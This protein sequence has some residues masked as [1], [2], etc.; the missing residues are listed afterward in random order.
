MQ[1][2]E[3]LPWSAGEIGAGECGRRSALGGTAV[4]LHLDGEGLYVVQVDSQY[5]YLLV[6]GRVPLFSVYPSFYR[7]SSHSDG[8]RVMV[9]G[10]VLVAEEPYLRTC[11]EVRNLSESLPIFDVL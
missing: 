2:R 3:A 9:G 10:K 11:T 1:L 6:V 7:H 8:M 4:G 5:C